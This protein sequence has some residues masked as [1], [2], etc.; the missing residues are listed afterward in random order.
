MRP[1]IG[2]EGNGGKARF[3]DEVDGWV[4]GPSVADGHRFFDPRGA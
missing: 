4:I 1:I 2:A 3:V